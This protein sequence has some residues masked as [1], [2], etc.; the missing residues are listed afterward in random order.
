MP[1]VSLWITFLISIR[2]KKK[3]IKWCQACMND[4]I[5]LV[6]KNQERPL[7]QSPMNIIIF[8]FKRKTTSTIFS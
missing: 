4:S 6:E 5:L 7:Q 2:K 1:H 3:T 8:H